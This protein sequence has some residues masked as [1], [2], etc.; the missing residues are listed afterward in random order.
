[1]KLKWQFGQ[2]DGLLEKEI[3]GIVGE[4]TVEE[5]LEGLPS[6]IPYSESQEAHLTIRKLSGK[7]YQVS[8]NIYKDIYRKDFEKVA[9]MFTV[10]PSL[11]LALYE[12]KEELKKKN[13]KSKKKEE[14]EQEEPFNP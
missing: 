9:V 4:T 6:E 10:Q 11:R 12:M 2:S 7:V 5:L 8:Y 1:M 14:D 13:S 3:K